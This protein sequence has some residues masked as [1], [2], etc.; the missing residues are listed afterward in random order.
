MAVSDRFQSL[1]AR[2]Q[3]T[4][5]EYDRYDTHRR[6]IARRLADAFPQTRIQ[7]I[8]SHSRRTAIHGASDLDLM[9]YFPIGS[10]RWGRDVSRSDTILAKLRTELLDRYHATRVRKD[11]QAVVVDFGQGV[12]NVDVVPAIWVAMTEPHEAAPKRRPIYAIPD[13]HRGWLQTSPQ[14]HNTFIEKENRATG[15]R[16][17][18]TAQLIKFWRECRTTVT[19]TSFYVEL[20]LA[21]EG[22]CRR[23]NGYAQHLADF[24]AVLSQRRCRGLRD[25]LGISGVISGSGSASQTLRAN[26]AVVLSHALARE[27]REA[28]L[29]R[30][31][32]RAYDL[33]R[34]VFN[35]QFP[36]G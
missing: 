31:V 26:E 27:A 15:G 4:D 12:Y 14:A 30:N 1:L 16:L 6:T 35:G 18:Y 22:I 10:A 9:V 21:S 25:P 23:P 3:P 20:V 36:A 13:G 28:E 33:W 34:R 2:I 32:S 24:F 17:R 11:G 29:G 8:G 7:V 19:L 5:A